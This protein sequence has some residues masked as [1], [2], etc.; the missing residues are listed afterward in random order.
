MPVLMVGTH[1]ENGTAANLMN[2]AWGGIYDD[3]L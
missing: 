3:N 1:D 2:A